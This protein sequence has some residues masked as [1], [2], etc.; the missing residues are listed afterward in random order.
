MKT[1]EF[2]K[3]DLLGILGCGLG[4]NIQSNDRNKI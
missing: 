4:L 2:N 3:G 1:T